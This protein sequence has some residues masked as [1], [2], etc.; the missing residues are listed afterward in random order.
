[1]AAEIALFLLVKQ[2]W[3]MVLVFVLQFY[4]DYRWFVGQWD[5]GP[6]IGTLFLQLMDFTFCNLIQNHGANCQNY[7]FKEVFKSV[8][9]MDI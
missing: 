2:S 8:K 1:M 5:H 9:G 4:G 3:T 7:D 6:S